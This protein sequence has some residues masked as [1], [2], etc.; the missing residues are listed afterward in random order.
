MLC[1]ARTVSGKRSLPSAAAA[2]VQFMRD[3]LNGKRQ[4]SLKRYE[5]WVL[6][7]TARLKAS[8]GDGKALTGND[9]DT[10]G[11]GKRWVKSHGLGEIWDQCATPKL[12]SDPT[13][14]TGDTSICVQMRAK[15]EH[16]PCR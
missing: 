4:A 5:N 13:R 14:H 8:F 1:Y 3:T 6:L 11:T 7:N 15:P 12:A 16:R 2:P 10:I 9:E